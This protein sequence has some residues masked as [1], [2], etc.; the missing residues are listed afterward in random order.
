MQTCIRAVSCIQRLAILAVAGKHKL[1]QGFIDAGG[2][3][4]GL[5]REYM[6]DNYLFCAYERNAANS[7]CAA[8]WEGEREVCLNN[9]VMTRPM[10]LLKPSNTVKHNCFAIL[11]VHAYLA[12]SA[13][14]ATNANNI[15]VGS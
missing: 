10:P 2:V 11:F 7:E 12:G 9:R 13:S 15:R 6:P 3:K 1:V 8:C 5:V 4:L 14:A